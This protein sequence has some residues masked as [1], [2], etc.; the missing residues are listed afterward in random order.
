[1]GRAKQPRPEPIPGFG[2]NG[3]LS[4]IA[5]GVIYGLHVTQHTKTYIAERCNCARKTVSEA[6]LYVQAVIDGNTPVDGRTVPKQLTEGKRRLLKRQKMLKS[7]MQKKY[8]VKGNHWEVR[9]RSASDVARE[10]FAQSGEHISKSTALRA[11]RAE[12]GTYRKRPVT[13]ALTP[14]RMALRVAAIPV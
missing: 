8:R 4:D 14:E 11:I 13:A 10:L 2:K 12:A 9:F 3:T 5:K 6:I 7:I 1:M